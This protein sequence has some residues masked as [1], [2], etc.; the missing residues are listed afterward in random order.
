MEQRSAERLSSANRRCPAASLS[1]QARASE[2]TIAATMD[3][4]S[5]PRLNTRRPAVAPRCGI[6]ASLICPTLASEVPTSLDPNAVAE[7]KSTEALT[8]WVS[9]APVRYPLAPQCSA[10]GPTAFRPP[11]IADKRPSKG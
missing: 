11:Q 9:T 2:H 1:A 8:S 7:T 6:R 3:A 5:T 10:G 4:P